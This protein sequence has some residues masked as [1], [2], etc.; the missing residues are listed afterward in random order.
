ML[1]ASAVG[2][3]E[4]LSYL[5]EWYGKGWTPLYRASVVKG[6]VGGEKKERKD[7]A[8]KGPASNFEICD[9]V[10]C[11]LTIISAANGL[12]VGGF[13]KVPWATGSSVTDPSASIFV[14]SNDK[15]LAPNSFPIVKCSEA[16]SSDGANISFG[17]NGLQVSGNA[18]TLQSIAGY[19]DASGKYKALFNGTQVPIVDI[20]VFYLRSPSPFLGSAIAPVEKLF[21]LKQLLGE[22]VY[23]LKWAMVYRGAQQYFSSSSL[24]TACQGKE[25]LLILVRSQDGAVFGG[26][27]SQPL[28]ANGSYSNDPTALLFT[29]INPCNVPPTKFSPSNAADACML[30]S[31]KGPVFG[32]G[33][34]AIEGRGPLTFTSN[35][36]A[37]F[38]DTS[39]K[40]KALFGSPKIAEIEVYAF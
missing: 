36:P 29:L 9:G 26:Y 34:L 11:T 20:E 35:F 27:T 33:D 13:L 32:R 16:F 15:D 1:H 24:Q 30:P 8:P 18:V 6:G 37:S 10:E 39:K 2:Q 4:K 40:G 5:H 28:I 3:K 31:T 23:N 21:G 14:L 25:K 19:A 22:S 12:L 17:G 7:P 38:T